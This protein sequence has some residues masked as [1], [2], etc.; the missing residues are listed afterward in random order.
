MPSTDPQTTSL[1][2]GLFGTF[3]VT[4]G[5]QPMRKLRTRTGNWLLALLALRHG[6]PVERE[7][8]AQALWPESAPTVANDNLRHCLTD[9]R[10][11]LGPEAVRLSSPT[12]TTLRLDVDG[13]DVDVFN[14]KAAI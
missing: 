10:K 1:R 11:A 4:I 9:L 6:A 12:R 5:G 14:F 8:L 13:A 2:I 3:S 7:W